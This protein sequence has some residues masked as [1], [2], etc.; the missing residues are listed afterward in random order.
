MFKKRSFNN[1]DDKIEN[2]N[3]NLNYDQNKT[4]MNLQ[5]LGRLSD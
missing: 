4:F 5:Y 3:E 1:Y 2:E